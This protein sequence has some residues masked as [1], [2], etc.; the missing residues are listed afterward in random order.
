[1]EWLGFS[2]AGFFGAFRS[3]EK[4]K[5]FELGYIEEKNNESGA[6]TT[7]TKIPGKKLWYSSLS[8]ENSGE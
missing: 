2:L 7:Q 5:T 6:K 1:M 8:Y 4:S 3:N